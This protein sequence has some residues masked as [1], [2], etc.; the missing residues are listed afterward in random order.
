AVAGSAYSVGAE[1]S[2][3]VR[4]DKSRAWHTRVPTR[5]ALRCQSVLLPLFPRA[6]TSLKRHRWAAPALLPSTPFD[7]RACAP[8]ARSLYSGLEG[9]VTWPSNSPPQWD[10]AQ[11]LSPAARSG[12]RRLRNWEPSTTSTQMRKHQVRRLLTW[13]EPI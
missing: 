4:S 13:V 11:L 3:T 1:T 6:W 8:G 12:R 2:F 7:M 10:I 9:W 5:K